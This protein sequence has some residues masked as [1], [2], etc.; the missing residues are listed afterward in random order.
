MMP[1]RNKATLSNTTPRSIMEIVLHHQAFTGPVIKMLKY[2]VL[3]C[4]W[5]G[6]EIL[7]SFFVNFPIK[8]VFSAGC[9]PDSNWAGCH[10][11]WACAPRPWSAGRA[12]CT[13]RAA[14]P[15]SPHP[16]PR[17]RYKR[18]LR[19]QG[20]NKFYL[21][22]GVLSASRQC[23]GDQTKR[24][25][26]GCP[27]VVQF[28]AKG[29]SIRSSQRALG[30]KEPGERSSVSELRQRR[31][32]WKGSPEG[33]GEA[34]WRGV[35]LRGRSG[36][37]RE[38]EV[39]GTEESEQGESRNIVLVSSSTWSWTLAAESCLLLCQY[40]FLSAHIFCLFTLKEKFYSF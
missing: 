25:Y 8:V 24:L 1:G 17:R 29:R 30:R 7:L 37:R 5:K 39:V 33:L 2:L 40:T 12:G 31:S 18:P 32:P 28:S 16:E 6:P 26:R 35:G 22:C 13:Q 20:E 23:A 21:S 10:W 15:G 9:C 27:V 4:F 11:N 36:R 14:A 34:A 19:D 38:T 3:K